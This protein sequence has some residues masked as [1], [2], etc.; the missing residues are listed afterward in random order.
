MN[1][2]SNPSSDPLLNLADALGEDIVATPADALLHEAAGEAGGRDG[3]VTAFDR[4]AARAAAQSR[5]RRIAE[6]LRALIDGVSGSITWRSAMAGVAGIFVVAVGGG[7]YVHQQDLPMRTA[8][9]PPR[10][11]AARMPETGAPA[12]AG[13]MSYAEDRSARVQPAA[14]PDHAAAAR[15]APAAAPPVAATA[16]PP[17]PPAAAGVA[18]ELQRVR[19]AD[20]RPDTA[21]AESAG[22]PRRAARLQ[23]PAEDR[24][25]TLAMAAEQ[26]R[27]STSP[28]APR[29]SAFA[30]ATP[31]NAPAAAASPGAVIGGLA[32]PPPAFQWPLRGRVLAGFGS[33]VGGAPNKGI[34]LA[35][36]AGTDIRAAE[37]GVVLYAGNEIKSFGNL[38][39]L[40][41]RDGFLTAYA[42]TQSFAVKPGDTVRRGQVIAKSGRTGAVSKP[43]LHFEIRKDNAPVDPARYLPPPG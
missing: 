25:A 7:L 34:D 16:P 35:A 22:A 1:S 3:A 8:A 31:S 36:A 33:P 24:L 26:K 6:R 37:D 42:H 27:L 19:T 10:D 14:K 40:R 15:P 38:L 18:D 41:H 5:R 23:P 28:P 4:I 43:Q 11:F 20:V 12:A 13:G 29:A 39:L 21:T 17:A 32:A 30:P 9:A 2:H